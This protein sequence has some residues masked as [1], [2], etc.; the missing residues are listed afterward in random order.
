MNETKYD[1]AIIDRHDDDGYLNPIALRCN[2][3]TKPEIQNYLDTISKHKNIPYDSCLADIDIR[4]EYSGNMA[5][6]LSRD[7]NGVNSNKKDYASDMKIFVQTVHDRDCPRQECLN[8]IQNGK[9]TDRF[10]I[11][12]IGK[13][14]FADKYA[15]QK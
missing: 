6:H 15:K 13:Q 3:M 5:M 4:L 9:C 7:S 1:V 11:D 2:P 14:F 12:I 8:N 10:V